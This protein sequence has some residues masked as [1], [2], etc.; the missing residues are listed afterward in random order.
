MNSYQEIVDEFTD[1]ELKFV[2]RALMDSKLQEKLY[3]KE[4]PLLTFFFDTRKQDMLY[5]WVEDQEHFFDTPT[6]EDYRNEADFIDG[7]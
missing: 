1:V 3:E 4:S 2:Y 6:E 5:E 7:G